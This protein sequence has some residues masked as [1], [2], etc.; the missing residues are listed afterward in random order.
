[1]VSRYWS[2]RSAHRVTN[3]LLSGLTYMKSVTL[4]YVSTP[5]FVGTIFLRSIA[6]SRRTK[7]HFKIFLEGIRQCCNFAVYGIVLQT[8]ADE[9]CAD[10]L[11]TTQGSL[12]FPAGSAISVSYFSHR[13]VLSL[14]LFLIL[15]LN[16]RKAVS[17]SGWARWALHEHFKFKI[18]QTPVS[19]FHNTF[20]RDW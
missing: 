8:F 4:P 5:L 10:Y 18:L 3:R 16:P 7:N 9:G 6:I 2:S 17:L 11:V 13:V 12:N 19:C 14:F 20:R 1:M 15:Y